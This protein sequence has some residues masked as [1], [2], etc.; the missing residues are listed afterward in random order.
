[1][2]VYK[3]F[4]TADTS[5]YSKYPAKNTG[6]DEILEV[7]V[8]NTEDSTNSLIPGTGDFLTDDLR[9]CV[10]KFSNTDLATLKSYSTGSW[11]SYLRL[12][13]ADAENITQEYSL[14]IKQVFQTWQ[15]GTG[16]FADSPETRNGACWYTSQSYYTTASNWVNPSY[17]I[18]QGGGSWTSVSS[19][20]TFD[21]NANKDINANVTNIVDSW[22]SS[23]YVNNGFLI[24]HTTSIENNSGSYITLNYFSNDTHTIYPPSLDIRWDD[25][26]YITGSL[27]IIDNSNCIITVANNVGTFKADTSIYK[28]RVNCRDKFPTRTFTTSSVYLNNKALP[29]TSYWSIQDV[30]TNDIVVDFDTSYTKISCD[31]ISSYFNMYMSGLEPERYYKLLIKTYLSS[32]EIIDVDNNLIFKIVK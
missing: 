7:S 32:G 15:A 13:I 31:S 12:Y 22:F 14:E 19:S 27:S 2:A 10:I 21:L 26:S 25:S 4:P 8:K 6:L 17:F 11:K 5:I 24:K 16:K 1:M 18:T 9:R 20:Q 28:F 30:K 29:A 3:I 23:S